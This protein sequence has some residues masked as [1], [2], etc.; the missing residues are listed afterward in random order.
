VRESQELGHISIADARFGE[1]PH[2]L[3]PPGAILVGM[4]NR[5]LGFLDRPGDVTQAQAPVD[6]E[7]VGLQAELQG[8]ELD[9]AALRFAQ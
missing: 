4:S 5:S 6:L 2:G 1:D 3:V 7:L 9:S 8:D